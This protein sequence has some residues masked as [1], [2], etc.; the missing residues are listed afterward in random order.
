L[1]GHESGV[2]PDLDNQAILKR[3]GL[4]SSAVRSD[5]EPSSVE[6]IGS[7][8]QAIGTSACIPCTGGGV[9]GCSVTSSFGFAGCGRRG[10]IG[11]T[12]DWTGHGAFEDFVIAPNRTIWH[13]WGNS[14]G[15]KVMPNNGLADDVWNVRLIDGRH[16][17]EVRVASNG[18]VWRS[19]IDANAWTPWFKV[20]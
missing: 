1:P 6:G 16:A 7:R 20:N 10:S 3:A 9:Q 5:P 15:W 12:K 18:S 14:G 8:S 4:P 19:V 2:L 17:V 11:W 13:A